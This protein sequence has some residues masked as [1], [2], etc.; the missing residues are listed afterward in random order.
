MRLALTI[1]EHWPMGARFF[2][3]VVGAFMTTVAV[4][5]VAAYAVIG[6]TVPQPRDPFRTGSFEFDL[7]PGW[8]CERDGTEYV[9][10]PPGKPPYPAIAIMAIKERGA[11]DNLGAYEIYLKEPRPVKDSAG[12]TT[13]SV[14]SY[15]RR[16]KLGHAEWVEA[17]HHGSEIS[18]YDTYY[19]ATNTA[20]LGIL[21]S[22][23]VEKSQETSYVRQL[24]A[25]M[26]TLNLYQR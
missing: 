23:S 20:L 11:G 1:P 6:L 5:G 19:L 15:V 3:S 26:G 8:W 9:C 12:H 2:I 13:Q 18:N 14:V 4:L 25:M 16:V 22:M 24:T 10:N 17:L 21:V 7:A